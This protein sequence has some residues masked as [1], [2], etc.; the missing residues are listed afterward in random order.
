M[1]L[2]LY[3]CERFLDIVPTGRVIPQNKEDFRAMLTRAYS[4]YPQHKALANLKSDEVQAGGQAEYLKAIF[5]WG[6]DVATAGSTEM[7]YESFYQVIF[8]SNYIIDNIS[9]YTNSDQ[10]VEQILGE[11][12]ALRAY[13]YFELLN[14][15]APVYSGQNG[16]VKSV[17][18]ITEV[19][20]ERTFPKATLN[21][22][23]DQIFK[24]ISF[25]K[26][27]INVNKFK[28]GYNYRF[29]KIA[30]YAF[31]ARMYQYRKEWD[32]ALEAA[33]NVL[34]NQS[35]LEDFSQF[36]VL[37][38]SYKSKE[39]IMNLDLPVNPS[40][41]SFSR[42][43]ESHIKLFDQDQ[44]LRFKYYFKR[45][46]TFWQTTKYSSSDPFKCTFRVGEI[47]LIKAEA[48][49]RLGRENNSKKTL[50]S[51]AKKRYT[52][53][54]YNNFEAKI[55]GLSNTSY[56]A[57]LLKERE[58]ETSFEGMRWFDLRRTTQPEMIHN[59]GG[60]DYKLKENDKRYT[61]PFPKSVKLKNPLL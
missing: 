32:K 48:Q 11:A 30:L 49:Q 50:L 38:S 6:E 25:A 1:S 31:E 24:D 56:L 15:Y 28:E 12:Y 21:E 9:K 44:D 4:I 20:L 37:P 16:A 43:S 46:G 52:S 18:L 42:V 40:T 10:E 45:N 14:L 41:N 34:K 35:D 33:E 19:D 8:Y 59:F 51:L 55:Q 23:Y 54:G 61:I 29:S 60:T 3:S 17:P 2:I 27:L 57:E 39:S 47:L 22:V 13:T 58:R 5:T 26:R 53:T 7:P 36:S